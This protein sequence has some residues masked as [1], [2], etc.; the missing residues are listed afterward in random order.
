MD[1]QKLINMISEG[2]MYKRVATGQNMSLGEL[3]AALN[4]APDDYNLR[5]DSGDTPVD[6]DSY[7][8]YYSD[9]AIKSEVKAEQTVGGFRKILEEAVGKTFEGYKGGEFVMAK[10]TPMW[11]SPWDSASGRAVTGVEPRDTTLIIMT[12]I[13]D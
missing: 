7:R 11:V 9:L 1:I 10:H 6:V 13:V 3:I 2:E 8:G 12:E 5:L 4:G